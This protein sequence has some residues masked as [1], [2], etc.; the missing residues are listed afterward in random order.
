M[1][2]YDIDF[3]RLTIMML[4]FALRQPR[5]MA[6]VY[7]LTAPVRSVYARFMAFR[8]EKEYRMAHNGQVCLLEKVLNEKL[9]GSYDPD[10]ALITVED[11]TEFAHMLA[12]YDTEIAEHQDYI[13]YS[14]LG[15]ST[16][17]ESNAMLYDMG[18]ERSGNAMFEVHLDS[19]LAPGSAGAA[20]TAYTANGGEP[21]LRKL[22]EV[23]KLAGKRYEIIQD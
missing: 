22:L 14:N 23:Y 1:S 11:V 3:R 19:V 8:T 18:S 9:C 20:R 2:R 16:V 5:M 17:D 10:V 12:P 7:Q 13:P 21:M 4:P 15:I 6:F